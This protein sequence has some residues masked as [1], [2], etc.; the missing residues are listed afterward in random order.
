MSGVKSA[1]LLLATCGA[2]ALAGCE[3]VAEEVNE[4]VGNE[5][6]A[7]LAPMSGGSGSGKADITLNDT[8]NM[9]C[10]DLELSNVGTVTAANIMGPGNTVVADIDIP[11]DND[12]DD[13]D[14]VTDGV[15][16]AIGRNPGA[17]FV[18]VRASTGDLHGVLRKER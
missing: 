10:T 3:T 6:E 1:H 5:Y 15:I 2:M 7:I 11:D 16:D 13:C 8:T 17:Y 14:N 12:S 18:H 9:I 4:A